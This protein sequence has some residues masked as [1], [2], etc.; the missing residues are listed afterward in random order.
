MKRYLIVLG[1]LI[2]INLYSQVTEKNF[3]DQNYIET[4]GTAE[5]EI[6]PDI[7][8]ATLTIRN[9]YFYAN[10]TF[11]IEQEQI[12]KKEL[13]DVGMD[14]ENDFR[15]M[16]FNSMVETNSALTDPEKYKKYYLV[17]RNDDIISYIKKNF[18]R[19]KLYR[20]DIQA[21]SSSGLDKA[22]LEISKKAMEIAYGKASAMVKVSNHSVGK[23]L[24]VSEVNNFKTESLNENR[25]FNYKPAYFTR[26]EIKPNMLPIK[27]K[28]TII[29]RFEI[30]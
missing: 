17:I 20:F 9:P 30:E 1:L 16:E 18:Y 11:F 8:Y 12:I 28:K 25:I 21:Y 27:L 10:R 14:V 7:F 2:S 13:A 22:E 15:P 29:A 5:T 19:L 4:Y 26:F 3:I 23:T 24:Y 6:L